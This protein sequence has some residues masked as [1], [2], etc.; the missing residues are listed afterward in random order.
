[1][2]AVQALCVKSEIF[3]AIVCHEFIFWC[4]HQPNDLSNEASLSVWRPVCPAWME[5]MLHQN[6]GCGSDQRLVDSKESGGDQ[7]AAVLP[8]QDFMEITVTSEGS[9]SRLQ[10]AARKAAPQNILEGVKYHVGTNN[11]LKQH[12]KRAALLM[13][14]PPMLVI[15]GSTKSACCFVLLIICLSLFSRLCNVLCLWILLSTIGAPHGAQNAW[16]DEF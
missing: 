5:T 16:R 2:E 12:S 11:I 4:Q 6:M 15:Q 3:K 1:M 9:Q 14:A 8:F 7:L 10:R 13:S